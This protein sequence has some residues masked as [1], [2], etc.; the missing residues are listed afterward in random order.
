MP[1]VASGSKTSLKPNSAGPVCIL[2]MGNTVPGIW[3]C[4]NLDGNVPPMPANEYRPAGRWLD[5]SGTSSG[6]ETAECTRS[7]P[8]GI[9]LYRACCIR[10]SRQ[11]KRGNGPRVFADATSSRP[12][13]F[14]QAYRCRC[15]TPLVAQQGC[16]SLAYRAEADQPH[17]DLFGLVFHRNPPHCGAQMPTLYRVTLLRSSQIRN[18]QGGGLCPQ[19]RI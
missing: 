2:R 1:R 6:R 11:E 18:V 19:N 10:W 12:R 17:P 15:R 5:K 7:R 13:S 16:Y 4:R 14:R 8:P 9:C 3:Y